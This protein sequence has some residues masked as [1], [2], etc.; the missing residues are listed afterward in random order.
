MTYDETQP[1]DEVQPDGLPRILAPYENDVFHAIM[2]LPEAHLALVGTVGAFIGRKLKTATLR[3]N[4]MP[5]RDKDAKQEN[6]DVNCVVD[7]EDGDQC[8]IE[9]QATHM[10]GDSKANYHRNIKWRSVFNACDLHVNQRGSGR[11]YEEF[12][13][14]Y[15]IMLCNYRVF[16]GTGDPAEPFT[17]RN[18]AGRELC[19]AVTVVF[20][21][22][23]KAKEIAEKPVEEMTDAEAWIVFFALAN[24]PKYRQTIEEITKT[25]EGIAVA[26]ET[27]LSISQDADERARLRSHRIW[28]QDREHDM[29][30]ARKEGRAELE[31]LLAEK[32]A[33]IADQA[34]L[35]AQLQARLGESD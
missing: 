32:D 10:R 30:V 9:M 17:F 14:S 24:K 4:S 13:R 7:G 19:N 29:A 11:D 16:D 12:V 3:N 28:L 1:S 27:L 23:T 35:I 2:T 26:N 22:L 34:A 6:L 20:V 25:W 15:Q 8:A 33:V 18:R 31:P 5:S 21:D